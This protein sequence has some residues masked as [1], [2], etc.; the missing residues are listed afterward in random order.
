MRDIPVP[1]RNAKNENEITMA[2]RISAWG[3]GLAI[4][5]QEPEA[6]RE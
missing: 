5:R 6:L 2:V 4:T 3:K 1:S